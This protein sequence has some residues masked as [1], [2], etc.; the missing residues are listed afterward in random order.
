MFYRDLAGIKVSALGYGCMRFPTKDGHI[1]EPEAEALLLRAYEGG[2]NYFDT[3]YVYHFMESEPFVGKVLSKLPRGTFH[4]ATKFPAWKPK[5]LEEAK[6]IFEFQLKNLRSDYVDF[7][8]V[9]ALNRARW[10]KVDKLGLM[11]L[12]EEYQKQGRIRKLG[13]SFHGT[14]E[15][16]EEILRSRRWD[17]CQLQFNY[18]DTQ[19][20]AGEKG[21]LLAEELG[22]GVVVME[23]VKGGALAAL[24][25]DVALPFRALAPEA[26]HASWALRFVADYGN[27]KVILSGMSNRAQLEDN[28]A[29]LA[30]YQPLSA[31]EKQAIA[32]VAEALA[33]RTNN[34]CTGCRYCMPCSN[35]VNIPH[36]FTIWNANARY[37][38]PD[39]SRG[40]Y[41][42]ASAD[43]R[44]DKCVECG[45]CVPMCPQGIDIPCDLKKMA[46]EPWVQKRERG[47]N[48]ND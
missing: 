6:E 40:D 32:Q 41:M 12:L 39:K 35:G 30:A 38:N 17:F 47:R 8:L 44:A 27:A 26:S 31:G 10:K 42:S 37:Q 11:P 4:L 3:A 45:A 19:D 21:F 24:P 13:F 25:E 28:L 15:E 36:M 14:Y 22:I 23:P 29:T 1:D 43:S 20:Q 34:G 5:S 46:A 2:V 18:M 33:R 48:K 9:H 16:Y 7:Y